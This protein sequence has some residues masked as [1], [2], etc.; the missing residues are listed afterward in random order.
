MYFDGS[1]G[2]EFENP[3]VGFYRSLMESLVESD[4]E[5]MRQLALPQVKG[6][7]N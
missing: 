5:M 7:L 6:I 2:R 4:L 1:Y 3:A